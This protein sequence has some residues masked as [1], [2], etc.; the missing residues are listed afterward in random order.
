M[1]INRSHRV[2]HWRSHWCR[3]WRRTHRHLHR[4][5]SHWHWHRFVF[6]HEDTSVICRACS[7]RTH[8]QSMAIHLLGTRLFTHIPKN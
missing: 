8:Q 4:R 1:N 2:R 3:Y 6:F 5:G 7:Y